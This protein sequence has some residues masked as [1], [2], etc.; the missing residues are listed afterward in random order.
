MA[1]FNLSDI[2][3]QGSLG[4]DSFMARE[5]QVV[6]P[7][8]SVRVASIRDLSGFT[9]LSAETLVHKADRDLWSIRRQ[10]DG[11][12]LI[13]RMFNDDGSPLKL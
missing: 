3:V 5:P 11:A 10:S 12:M 7:F 8:K 4:M 9:R 1:K 2:E 6:A 13:E